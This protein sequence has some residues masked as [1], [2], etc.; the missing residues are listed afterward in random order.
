MR[1]PG[2]APIFGEGIGRKNF[3][4]EN[5]RVSE[6]QNGEAEEQPEG[7]H[8]KFIRG[9]F[10]PGHHW[11]QFG[12]RRSKMQFQQTDLEREGFL[13][14]G[15]QHPLG[16]IHDLQIFERLAGREFTGHGL[17]TGDFGKI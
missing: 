15:M 8:V 10:F 12:G 7:E 13:D 17:R 11:P 3:L 2:I 1:R 5:D 6:F 4:V 16:F 14:I 9:E